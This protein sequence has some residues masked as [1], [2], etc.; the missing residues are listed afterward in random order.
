MADLAFWSC[1]LCFFLPPVPLAARFPAGAGAPAVLSAEEST[2]PFD[3]R[4]GVG[5]LLRGVLGVLGVL[6]GLLGLMPRLLRKPGQ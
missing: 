3:P 6:G 1:L 2:A 5:L 4:R